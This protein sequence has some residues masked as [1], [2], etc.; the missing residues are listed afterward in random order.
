M[1][2][3]IRAIGPSGAAEYIPGGTV[4]VVISEKNTHVVSVQSLGRSL[5]VFAA[6]LEALGE[7]GNASEDPEA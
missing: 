7:Q 5:T 3:K 6:D 2:E 1:R 4:V